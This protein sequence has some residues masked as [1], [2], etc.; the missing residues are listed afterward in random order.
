MGMIQLIAL[1]PI[2]AKTIE[3]HSYLRTSHKG[4]VSEATVIEYLRKNFF[5]TFDAEWPFIHKSI[6]SQQAGTG[7]FRRRHSLKAASLEIQ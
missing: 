3:N 6:N 4:R 2:F 1:T 5:L 7:F